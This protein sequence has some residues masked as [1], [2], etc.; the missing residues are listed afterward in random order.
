MSNLEKPKGQNSGA[1]ANAKLMEEIYS[2]LK[3]KLPEADGND[4]KTVELIKLLKDKLKNP[5]K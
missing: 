4:E 3:D 5:E 1:E 2:L